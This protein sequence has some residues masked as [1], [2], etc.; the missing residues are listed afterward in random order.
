MM[1]G[2]ARGCSSSTTPL[3]KLTRCV[4][5]IRLKFI[6]HKGELDKFTDQQTQVH[7]KQLSCVIII[8]CI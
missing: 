1:N 5:Q 6:H 7:D 2:G 4:H 3:Q 8:I